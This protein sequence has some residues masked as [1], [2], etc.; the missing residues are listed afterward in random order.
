M[1]RRILAL[2]A[3]AV[4]A[5]VVATVV[6]ARSGSND[7]QAPTSQGDTRA[8]ALSYAPRNA[9]ALVGVDTGSAAASLVLGALVPR[10]SGGALTAN[11]VSPLLGNEAV[12]AVLDPRTQRAQLSMVA[13]DPDALRALTRRLTKA[14]TY[15]GATLY[16]AA[17]GAALAVKGDTVVAASDE[18][19]VRRAIDTA[20][21]GAHHLTPA[22]FDARLAGLPKTADVRAVFD[23]KRVVVATRLPGVLDTRWGRSL[24]N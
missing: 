13:K 2:I 12:V 20:T 11:D 6:I 14:G 19:T 23:P 3:V 10:V 21:N 1:S 9:P 17:Q 16:R 5:I 18:P 7:E 4:A 8:E 22:Q 24:T 15:H